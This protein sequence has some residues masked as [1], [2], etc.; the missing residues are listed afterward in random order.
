[1]SLLLALH[2]TASTFEEIPIMLLPMAMIPLARQ[3]IAEQIRNACVNVKGHNIP[4][5]VIQ[6]AIET[7]TN[8]KNYKGYTGL[9][10]ENTDVEHGK[11]D[12]HEGFDLG[13]ES[14]EASNSEGQGRIGWGLANFKKDLLSY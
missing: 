13:F 5:Q 11:G 4:E 7:S 3:E 6:N 10:A 12:L 2:R 9:L 1:M 14:L 8:S